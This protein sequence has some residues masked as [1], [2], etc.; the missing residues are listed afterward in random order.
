MA[1]GYFDKKS[2]GAA[3]KQLGKKE[4]KAIG[5]TTRYPCKKHAKSALPLNFCTEGPILNPM[6]RLKRHLQQKS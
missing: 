6:N 1:A 2:E 5:L 3:W 4:R